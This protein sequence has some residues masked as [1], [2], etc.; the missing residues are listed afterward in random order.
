MPLFSERFIVLIRYYSLFSHYRFLHIFLLFQNERK[1]EEEK[2]Q[3]KRSLFFTKK[4]K[5]QGDKDLLKLLSKVK[6][7]KK[8]VSFVRKD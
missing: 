3:N 5:L 8:R 7:K 2:Q 6:I 1:E 4:K